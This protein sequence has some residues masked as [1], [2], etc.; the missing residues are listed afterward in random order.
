[1]EQS[2]VE[3][4]EQSRAVNEGAEALKGTERRSERGGIVV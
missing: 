1:V 2:V 3:S 4:W